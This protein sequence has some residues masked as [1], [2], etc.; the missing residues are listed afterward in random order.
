MTKKKFKVNFDT[1]GD[2]NL[3]KRLGA[4]GNGGHSG[5]IDH[6]VPE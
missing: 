4:G 3:L 1:I 5:A 2:Y 6:P